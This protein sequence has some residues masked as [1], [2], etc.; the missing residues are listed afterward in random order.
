MKFRN[1][2]ENRRA[3]FVKS[4]FSEWTARSYKRKGIAI[5]RTIQKI[6]RNFKLRPASIRGQVAAHI[7][8]QQNASWRVIECERINRDPVVFRLSSEVMDS[9]PFDIRA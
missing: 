3:A 5:S 4:S 8:N 6:C 1:S 2:S 9:Q 7:Q